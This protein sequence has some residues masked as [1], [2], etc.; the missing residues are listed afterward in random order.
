[1]ACYS[2]L[3]DIAIAEA[4]NTASGTQTGTISADTLTG[5]TGD[6][7]IFGQDGNDLLIGADGNDV[8]LGEA[9]RDRLKGGSG[10]DRLYFTDGFLQSD[11]QGGQAY[12]GDG[13]D[14]I[15]FG[16]NATP[17]VVID[18]GEGTDVLWFDG[19]SLTNATIRN[20]EVLEVDQTIT[21]RSSD[22]ERFSLIKFAPYTQISVAG[23]GAFDLRGRV[24][25]VTALL[26][27]A[28]GF[29]DLHLIGIDGADRLSG[30]RGDDT[31]TGGIGDDSLSNGD[32]GFPSV[33]WGSDLFAGGSGNDV[34]YA[35]GA[36][37]SVNA[38]NGNDQI[39][40][41]GGVGDVDGGNGFD[42]VVTEGRSLGA[43]VFKNVEQLLV[44][45]DPQYDLVASFEQLASFRLIG[46]E[47]D[48]TYLGRL[49]LTGSGALDLA[50]KGILQGVHVAA[51][52]SA[53][54]MRIAGTI[55]DDDFG[56]SSTNDTLSG[57]GGQD[58][59]SGADGADI[60]AGEAGDDSIV[61][62]EGDDQLVG[63]VGNDTLNG[64]N[65]T[66]TI[67]GGDGDDTYLI[68]GLG[69]RISENAGR[70]VDTVNTRISWTLGRNFENL[71][72][73]GDQDLDGVGN[74]LDNFV[75]AR[76][77]G[78]NSVTGLGG[79]DRVLAW[80]GND[81]LAGNAGDDWLIGGDD[82][83]LLQGGVGDDHLDGGYHSDRLV[84]G[85]GAD[86]FIFDAMEFVDTILD[87]SVAEDLIVIDAEEFDSID[88]GHDA[89]LE[90]RFFH[91]GP[92][93][94]DFE[95]RIIYNSRR[96]TLSYDSDGA[97]SNEAVVFARLT[98]GL[99]L[100]ANDI[101]YDW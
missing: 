78:N 11:G 1:M 8:L 16:G 3:G 5:G 46:T 25:P 13:D 56:G 101:F 6:D 10:N 9:G 48:P 65:G 43:G 44:A 59:L 97:G 92:A 91:I 2:R 61:G 54:N 86:N 84:G 42:T 85:M 28:Q 58:T 69:D 83:D 62:G 23:S 81:T 47:F 50:K 87:F 32:P 98:K 39:G 17:A 68:D 38:G 75:D 93:A 18:G 88:N 95:H 64:G 35:V 45:S 40:L 94:S 66:D 71:I 37:D 82:S 55:G 27:K 96:G 90:V 15:A 7:T 89:P 26:L 34:I 70:G 21:L 52:A 67:S 76:G 31:L 80:D 19:G 24:D 4:S 53:S 14:T 20:I 79:D 29:G 72:L 60:L 22:L 51:R 77:D 30:G 12:G 74:A 33:A 57:D 73:D 63:S 36:G 100:T 41:F 99:A 49:S